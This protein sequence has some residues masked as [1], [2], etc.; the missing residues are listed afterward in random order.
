[1]DRETPKSLTA[2]VEWLYTEFYKCMVMRIIGIV[3]K[4]AAEDIVQ[5]LMSRLLEYKDPEKLLRMTPNELQSYAMKAVFNMALDRRRKILREMALDINTEEVEYTDLGDFQDMEIKEILYH[6]VSSL[7][8]R[9]REIMELHIQEPELTQEEIAEQL[10][11]HRTTVNR[12][13]KKAIKLLRSLY[14]KQGYDI[15]E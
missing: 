10:G 9:E 5:T 3:G 8:Q 14:R 13:Y 2:L 6:L 4:D 12:R 1:M 7:P 11:L 15:R